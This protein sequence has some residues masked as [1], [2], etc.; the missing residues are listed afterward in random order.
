V[1]CF[2]AQTSNTSVLMNNEGGAAVSSSRRL[3]NLSQL[4]RDDSGINGSFNGSFVRGG[5]GSFV[6]SPRGRGESFL[7]NGSE[8]GRGGARARGGAE[9]FLSNGSEPLPEGESRR[10]GDNGSRFN[11]SFVSAGNGSGDGDGDELPGKGLP[12]REVSRGARGNVSF[13][14]MDDDDPAVA[15]AVA[16]VAA[17]EKVPPHQK[18]KLQAVKRQ[19][20][21]TVG[22]GSGSGGGG[23][24]SGSGGGGGGGGGG[25]GAG[26]KPK[27][28]GGHER[29]PSATLSERGQHQ[30]EGGSDGP[31]EGGHGGGRTA[32]RGRHVSHDGTM[33]QPL[34]DVVR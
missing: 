8:G 24:G 4:K 28:R 10:R 5:D 14:G 13:V 22:G 16:A 30:E 6:A 12:S 18:L 3:A 34:L 2:A 32:G 31:G 21:G 26:E 15:A 23:G 20:S 1:L 7:S 11:E 9:S 25:R 33:G 17:A 27:P 29:V 19:G